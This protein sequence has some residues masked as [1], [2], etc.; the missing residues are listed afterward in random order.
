MST[1][2]YDPVA[3]AEIASAPLPTKATLAQRRNVL[4]QLWRF[5]AFNLMIVRVIGSQTA[6]KRG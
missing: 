2:P 4:L 6:S 1:E 5:F 3:A